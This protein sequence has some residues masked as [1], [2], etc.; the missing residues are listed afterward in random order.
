MTEAADE[1]P[2]PLVAHRASVTAAAAP[3]ALAVAGAA[4]RWMSDDGLSTS[5][6]VDNALHGHGLVF[7]PASVEAVTSRS[8]S[9]SSPPSAPPRRSRLPPRGSAS[10]SGSRAPSR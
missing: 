1:D 2:P 8:G 10:P 7:N 9:S 3:Q 4:R 6:V 5:R